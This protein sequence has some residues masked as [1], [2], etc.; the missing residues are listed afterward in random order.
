MGG[1]GRAHL[2]YNKG[3]KIK[4]KWDTYKTNKSMVDLNI[5][6]I[7]PIITLNVNGLNTQL[8]WEIVRQ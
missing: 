4:K 3:R 2:V 7:I 8:K 5:I 6:P 1:G